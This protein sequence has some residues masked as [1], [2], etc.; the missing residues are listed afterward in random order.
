LGINNNKCGEAFH[1]MKSEI[2]DDYSTG[3]IIIIM[4]C[5]GGSEV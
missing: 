4:V 3:I 2:L 5:F 1:R